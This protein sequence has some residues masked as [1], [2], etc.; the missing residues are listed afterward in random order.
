MARATTVQALRNRGISK[1]TAEI[2]ADAGFTLEKLA[3]SKAE[4]LAKFS[5]KK[6][7]EKVRKKLGTARVEAKPAPKR[8]KAR[9]AARPRRTAAK[10][11]EAEPE[12]PLTIPTKAPPLTPGEQEI[13][14][15]LKEIG[16]WLPRFVVT[17]LSKKIHG[18][19]LSKKRLQE[20]LQK[21]CEKFDLHV[22]DANESA[23]IVSAQSIGEP[24][25][26]M[27]MRTFHYAGVAE[28][29]VT[30]GLPRLIEIVDARRVPSTPI[31]EL[32]V[33]S[34][35]TDLERM[36]KIATEIE[37]TSLEDIASIETDLVN[38]RVLAYPD[39]HRM[40]SRGVTWPE[41][42]EKLKKLGEIQ[43][44]RRQVGNVE[45]KT[46][47]LVVEAGEPSF[48]KLQ[49][50]AP[51]NRPKKNKHLPR[52]SRG[53]LQKRGGEYVTSTRR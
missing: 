3:A 44:V 22:I 16:R 46:R 18:L 38:M 47:A 32:Y 49:R 25:T 53:L 20:V 23:G 10:A 8:E 17:E 31:M 13:M 30:L 11:A 4:R 28:M 12:A 14:D 2:L 41:L 35:H 19:K 7:A 50:L 45:R 5:P 15:G 9:P 1:K 40:K 42:E 27:T 34:G 29:N 37:M 39:D 36:R 51:R 24:G 26:Q 48:K 21:I 43:E 33:K 52:G 6:E